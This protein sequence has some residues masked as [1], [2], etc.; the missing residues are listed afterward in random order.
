MAVLSRHQNQTAKVIAT[1]NTIATGACTNN[2]SV[3]FKIYWPYIF[4]ED[5]FFIFN[6]TV[7]MAISQIMQFAKIFCGCYSTAFKTIV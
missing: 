6:H 1:I 2:S 7:V 4:Y 3:K 5:L